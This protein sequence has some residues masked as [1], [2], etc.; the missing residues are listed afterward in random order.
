[1][2]GRTYNHQSI[3]RPASCDGEGARLGPGDAG[4]GAHARAEEEGRDLA[5]HCELIERRQWRS[6]MEGREMAEGRRWFG[7]LESFLVEMSM[8]NAKRLVVLANGLL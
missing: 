2:R 8:A 5:R 7:G 6:S 4:G 3:A 1:M